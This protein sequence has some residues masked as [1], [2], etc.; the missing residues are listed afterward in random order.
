MNIKSK[1]IIGSLLGSLLTV[2][3]VSYLVG[4]TA[5]KDASESLEL[6]EREALLSLRHSKQIEVEGYFKNIRGQL[7]TYSNNQMT[8]DAMSG[9][10]A[11]FKDIG[12][13]I[14]NADPTTKA[15]NYDDLKNYY[16]GPFTD[17]FKALN[18]G[19]NPEA[20]GL[21]SGLDARTLKLQDLY[22]AQNENPLGSKDFK[23]AANDGSKYSE[24]HKQYHPFIRSYLQ[25]FG[26]YDIF[27]VNNLGDVVYSVFKELDYATNLNSGPYANSGLAEA[28][29]ASEPSSVA[30][31]A[32]STIDFASYYP[33]YNG[34]A[35]FFSSPIYDGA[36]KLGVLIMQAPVDELNKLMTSNN[37]WKDVGL[38]DS[39]ETYIVG[40]DHLL[41]NDSRFLIEDSTNYFEALKAAGDPNLSK[42]E[43]RGTSIGLQNAIT[44]G[45]EDAL[46]GNTDFAIFSDYRG[47]NVLSAY[48]PLNIPGLNWV[49]MA[50]IDEEE[51]FRSIGKI[52]SDIIKSASLIGLIALSLFGLGAFLLIRSITKPLSQL[53]Q[54][55]GLVASGDLTARAKMDSADELEEL[56]NTFD[57]MLDERIAT[58]VEAEK[59]NKQLNDSVIGL[60]NATSQLADKDLTIEVPVAEDVTGTVSD[61]LN[62][63]VEETSDVL[64]EISS[65]SK[66]VDDSV[67]LVQAQTNASKGASDDGK[68]IIKSTIDQLIK[69]SDSIKNIGGLVKTISKLTNKV[70]ESSA[71][72]AKTVAKNIEGMSQIR[73]TVTETEKRIERLGESSREI[74]NII[75]IINTLSERT[76][77]LAVSASM[78]AANAGEAGIE[79]AVI[80]QE[81]KRIS[82]SSKKSTFEITELINN[83]KK[84][85]SEAISTMSSTITRVN[86]GTNL[87]GKV[88]SEMNKTQ[89]DAAEL[90][91]AI[92]RISR[93]SESQNEANAVMMAQAN[94]V[95][96]STEKTSVALDKQSVQTIKLVAYAEKLRSEVGSFK[97]PMQ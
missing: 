44:Q 9:F 82:E 57:S 64:I 7:A 76:N 77:I 74:G 62:M 88:G 42:I 50:E 48:T 10:T 80:A 89:L 94:K 41:R 97:L 20:L 21:L 68:A 13:E 31:N 61:A 79:F 69:V 27:L 60:M 63:M 8:I 1:I 28:F 55:M 66:Q 16:N 39:G 95:L 40:S 73:D 11:A 86:E 23:I 3:G 58:M 56:G 29:R 33:S 12:Q 96:N 46:R 51:A 71:T 84:G 52:E 6:V 87:A 67:K 19:E 92:T 15:N 25:Q 32:V 47:V 22:I 26:Y 34:A 53:K 91:E 72:T 81:I 49:L 30:P 43:A 59:Q 65:V 54:T 5:I 38:G 2:V 4:T 14:I 85:A 78:Q 90:A 45:T 17:K 70:Q 36:K 18:N 83:I 37:S 24:L 35:A 75:D 93:E